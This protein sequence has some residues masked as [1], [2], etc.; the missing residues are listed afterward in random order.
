MKKVLIILTIIFIKIFSINITYSL[1]QTIKNKIDSIYIIFIKGIEKKFNKEDKIKL[2]IS[3][4]TKLE[5]IIKN[6][7]ISA[8]NKEVL[9]YLYQVNNKKLNNDDTK[10]IINE[11]NFQVE[12]NSKKNKEINNYPISKNFK[13]ISYNKD[14]IF[15]ENW[16]WYS[17]IINDYNYFIEPNKITINDLNN[18]WINTSN[19][20][21]FYL[22]SK[23]I[24]F[25]NNYKKTKL[26]S[27][28]IIYWIENK[29]NFLLEIKD[30]KKSLDTDYDND[31]LRLKKQTLL[32][33]EW[34]ST[35]EKLKSIYNYILDNVS[36]SKLINFEDKAIFSWIELY[37]NKEWV[38]EWYSKLFMYMINFAGIWNSEIIR[39]HVINAL[40]F[41]EIWHSWVKVW[42]K[43]YDP[44]FDDPLWSTITRSYEEYRF[45][46]LP[47]DIFYSNRFTYNNLPEYLKTKSIEYRESY[48]QNNLYNIAWKYQDKDYLLLKKSKFK[49]KYNYLA[50][51]KITLLNFNK[52][53]PLY[54]VKKNYITIDGKEHFISKL[55]FYGINDDSLESILEQLDYNLDSY[56]FLK[57]ENAD[58]T[59]EYRLWYNLEL[60]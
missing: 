56:Y 11:N 58:L 52:I 20:L 60:K 32:L 23:N 39:W 16:V 36:F 31:F 57:W 44:T 47:Y 10:K 7:K 43:Y 19:T 49:I 38:C 15:L 12:Y 9:S 53:I 41:P 18:N 48:I 42:D 25:A 17:Y 34:L 33:T 51:E 45:F 40:D 29:Y 50:D 28:D 21:L 1:D 27:D 55:H 54:D 13:N 35:D 6:K 5:A 59:N 24:W 46:G 22:D 30:D 2:L 8:K 4:D 14:N 37:N 3:L 26:I